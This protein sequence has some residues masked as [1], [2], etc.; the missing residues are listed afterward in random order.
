MASEQYKSL[1]IVYVEG[2]RKFLGDLQ[3]LNIPSL[4]R[5]EEVQN[6][7]TNLLEIFNNCPDIEILKNIFQSQRF[8]DKITPFI[9]SETLLYYAIHSGV[10]KIKDMLIFSTKRDMCSICEEC[11]AKLFKLFILKQ[12]FMSFFCEF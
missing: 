5:L 9:H 1:L 12:Y 6:Q 4:N 8:I 10:I 7:I 11:L 2:L 3:S